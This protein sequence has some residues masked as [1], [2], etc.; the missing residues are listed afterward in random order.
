MGKGE[1][2]NFS[3]G[4]ENEG[5]V[6]YSSN[7]LKGRGK[8]ASILNQTPAT[9]SPGFLIF[10]LK[11]RCFGGTYLTEKKKVSHQS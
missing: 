11:L 5:L 10:N 9:T 4:N 8:G 6:G 1:G 3:Y 2:G 7:R